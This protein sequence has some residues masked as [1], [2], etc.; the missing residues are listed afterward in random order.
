MT[1]P[2]PTARERM[3]KGLEKARP[4]QERAALRRLAAQYDPARDEEVDR[5][6]KLGESFRL[7]PSTRMEVGFHRQA[8]AAAEE[9]ARL[10][11]TP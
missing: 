10:E 7:S 3:A 8:K 9:L 4:E 2:A 1:T 11:G 5:V 6:A